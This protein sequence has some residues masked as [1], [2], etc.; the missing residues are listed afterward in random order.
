MNP[1]KRTSKLLVAAMAVLVFS[2]PTAQAKKPD[3]PGGGKRGGGNERPYSLVDLEGFEV[4]NYV[5]DGYIQSYAF[6]LNNA[7]GAGA[8]KVV[9]QSFVEGTVQPFRIAPTLWEVDAHGAFSITDLGLLPLE[10]EATANDINDFGEIV[11]TT[12]QSRELVDGHPILP[13]WLLSTPGEARQQ[14][15]MQGTQ[16]E[17]VAINNSGEIP[18]SDHNPFPAGA[19]WNSAAPEVEIELGLFHPSDIDESGVMA[20][21]EGTTIGSSRGAPAIAWFD[22]GGDLEVQPLQFLGPFGNATSIS[23]NG[24]FVA[25][26]LDVAGTKEAFVWTDDTGLVTLGT[27]GGESSVALGVNDS[28]QVVGWSDTGGGKYFRTA[29]LW[30]NG[31]MF[32]LNALSQGGG[33]NQL[34]EA[35]AINNSGHIA[36]Y[37]AVKSKGGSEEHAFVLLPQISSLSAVSSIPE[38]ASL[39][40]FVF[41]TAMLATIHRAKHSKPNP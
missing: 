18:G 14:L 17:A 11:I 36:G 6:S 9:G 5:Y 25:G 16:A 39:A 7:D 32:D 23:Q 41:G 19:Y 24:E 27:L 28:G 33:G 29:F 2:L 10:Q 22:V 12:N 31:E 34:L 1:A 40:L 30:D 4:P 20:G 26:Y 38:P 15:S 21:Y 37:M 35:A 3:N 8:I 13:T